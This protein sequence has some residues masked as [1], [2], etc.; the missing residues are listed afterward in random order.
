MALKPTTHHDPKHPDP[1]AAAAM[2]RATA[3]SAASVPATDEI[4]R[5]FYRLSIVG[6]CGRHF[7]TAGG[8]TFSKETE[9]L[10]PDPENPGK[11]RRVPLTGAVTPLFDDQLERVKKAVAAKVVR[12]HAQGRVDVITVEPKDRLL[13]DEPLEEF[14]RIEAL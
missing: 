5:R 3:A 4:G 9:R 1:G 14:V 7:L 12:R 2:E 6:D 13:T 11:T 10:E 8:Q